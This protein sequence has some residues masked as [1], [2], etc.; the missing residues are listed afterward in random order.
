MYCFTQKTRWLAAAALLVSLSAGALADVPRAVSY[1]GRLTGYESEVVDLTVTFWDKANGGASLFTETHGGIGLQGGIFAIRIGSLSGGLPDTALDA[2]DIWLGLSVD[3]GPELPR[4]RLLS[5]P[6]SMRSISAEE[7][8][9]PGTIT[10][11]VTVSGGGAVNVSSKIRMQESG[12]E[13]GLVEMM[14]GTDLVTVVVDGSGLDAGGRITLS[15]GNAADN[16][17]TVRL[18][19][20]AQNAGQIYLYDGNN[21]EA[22]RMHADRFNAAPEFSMFMGPPGGPKRETVQLV[23]N[24]DGGDSATGGELVLR[25]VADPDET[26]VKTAEL[27]GFSESLLD[28]ANA[29]GFLQLSDAAGTPVFTVQSGN[30]GALF[31]LYM[32]MNSPQ[33]PRR[34]RTSPAAVTMYNY[35]DALVVQ[36]S[37]TT[38]FLAGDL[39][40]AGET[41][42]SV[43]HIT[44]GSDLSERFDIAADGAAVTP[45]MV[46]C[47]D[48]ESPGALRV[49][50]RAYDSTVAGVVSGAGGVNVGML[51]GQAGTA[52]DGAHPV[53]LTGRVWVQC[54]A[55]GAA[56]TPG[57]L[58]TTSAT[59]G[60]AMR[61]GDRDR[62]QGATIGKAMTP[63]AAGERGLVLV[64]VN[65]Q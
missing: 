44:G 15:N 33:D 31:P 30:M 52:A 39:E 3:G 17:S 13:A 28:G 25:A 10:P 62:A 35:D 48:P 60:H 65:L 56:I 32:E 12:D 18:D 34:I 36:L 43:L 14:N 29:G 64:L 53:A 59:P 16:V 38:N 51:M 20:D 8:V 2:G 47:I 19:G 24:S 6:F 46:V 41:T 27:R 9:I 22:V 1:Q 45:G 11:I 49:S 37:A 5:V 42:T 55:T 63:L 50:T 54:D 40:V 26:A 7:L 61:A 21:M 23:A 58:L 4:T 57:D